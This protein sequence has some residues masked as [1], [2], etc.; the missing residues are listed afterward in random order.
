MNLHLGNAPATS[1]GVLRVTAVACAIAV[2]VHGMDHL[3]RGLSASPKSVVIGGFIQAVLVATAVV[4]TFTR[5][6]RT[7]EIAIFVGFGSAILFTYAHVLPKWIHFLSDS[8]VS[9]PHSG[10]TWFS[11]LTAVIEITADSAF[12]LAGVRAIRTRQEPAAR[13]VDVADRGLPRTSAR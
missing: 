10:V 3:R 8:F 6:R 1:D 5:Y 13:I 7:P 11:W 2:G 4:L 9:A 12:A